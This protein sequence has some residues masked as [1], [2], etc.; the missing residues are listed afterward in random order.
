MPIV[1]R[2]GDTLVLRGK[3]M[4]Y[5]LRRPLP[6][7]EVFLQ[8]YVR[9]TGLWEDIMS[10]KTDE[11]GEY[12]FELKLPTEEGS[13]RFRVCFKGTDEYKK[14]CSPPVTV[15]VRKPKAAPTVVSIIA[16]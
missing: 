13:Y 11:N 15:T 7:M 5:E 4:D 9:T 10:T 14:D 2:P 8:Q 3:L 1:K 6:G 12:V 16:E